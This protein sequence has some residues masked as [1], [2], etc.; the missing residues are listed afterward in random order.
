MICDNVKTRCPIRLSC[1]VGLASSHSVRSRRTRAR[2]GGRTQRLRIGLVDHG[3]RKMQKTEGQSSVFRQATVIIEQRA[4]C[5]KIPSSARS[6]SSKAIGGLRSR[7]ALLTERG[8]GC[9]EAPSSA[10][11]LISIIHSNLSF[12]PSSNLLDLWPI[13]RPPDEMYLQVDCATYVVV[14]QCE[15]LLASSRSPA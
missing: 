3:S 6:A 14:A 7:P 5:R 11:R 12:S 4:R 15:T 8:C 10:S 1:N 2:F 13:A 9:A